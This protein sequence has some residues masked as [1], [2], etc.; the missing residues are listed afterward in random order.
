MTTRIALPRLG[1]KF[2]STYGDLGPGFYDRAYKAALDG[3]IPT[4]HVNGRLYI[5]EANLDA[6]AAALGL[7]APASNAA[8]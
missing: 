5:E 1:A 2:A 4:V 8:A 3:R 7:R 6:V